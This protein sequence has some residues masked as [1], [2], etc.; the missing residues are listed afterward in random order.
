M[1]KDNE[2]TKEEFCSSCAMGVVAIAGAVGAGAGASSKKMHKKYKK[3]LIWVGI[4]T[5]IISIAV[6]G[7]MWKQNCKEC[8]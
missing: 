8:R 5:F 2:D 4:A 6:A 3:I 7:Y 1:K